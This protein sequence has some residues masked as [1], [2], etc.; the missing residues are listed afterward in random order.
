MMTI[1]YDERKIIVFT[2]MNN[3]TEKKYITKRCPFLYIVLLHI[4]CCHSIEVLLATY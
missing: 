1:C 4:L 3:A 2:E